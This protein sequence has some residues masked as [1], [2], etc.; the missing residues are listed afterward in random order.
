VALL[1]KTSPVPAALGNVSIR[2]ASFATC[3]FRPVPAPADAAARHFQP[4]AAAVIAASSAT[5]IRMKTAVSAAL[6]SLLQNVVVILVYVVILLVVGAAG[7][8]VPGCRPGPA[9]HHPAYDAIAWAPL[10]ASWRR[11]GEVTSHVGE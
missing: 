6:A 2:T 4:P 3:A 1:L 9:A 7:V 5:P 8:A 10:R 11:A